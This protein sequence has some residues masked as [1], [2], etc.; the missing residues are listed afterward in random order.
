[1]NAS[2]IM[3]TDHVTVQP[4]TPV[5]EVARLLVEGN[6]SGVAV[7]DGRG[8]LRGV[9]TAFDLVE[10]HARVQLPV[11][12]GILGTFIPFDTRRTDDDVRHALAVTAQ[13]LMTSDVPTVAPDT[14]VDDVASA[15]VDS[16][17]DPIPVVENKQVVGVVSHLDIARLLLVEEEGDRGHDSR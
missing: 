7:T 16:R 11:Y 1:M 2:D 14:S 9:V 10:K 8:A 6:L 3:S 15:M 5:G 13:D 12:L 17:I 4:D